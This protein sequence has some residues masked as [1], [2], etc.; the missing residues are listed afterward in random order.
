MK[1]PYPVDET[2]MI[3]E[4]VAPDPHTADLVTYV[5]HLSLSTLIDY[6]PLNSA[7]QYGYYDRI[8]E[9]IE[10][11]PT[12]AAKPLTGNVTLLHWAAINNRIE[13]AEYLI[14]KRAQI[15]AFGG[16]LNSTPLHWAIRDGKLPMVAFLLSHQ[17]Q[18][19]LF[20]GEGKLIS[21]LIF[22]FF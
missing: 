15:D 21:Y 12:L 6:F 22:I 5:L 7:V 20:D 18:A 9:L 8:V 13:I 19:S 4:P 11:E 16:E 3:S 2:A 10:P 17:A 14:S 1:P